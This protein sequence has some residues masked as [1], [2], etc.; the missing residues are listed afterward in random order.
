MLLVIRRE[1]KCLYIVR[2]SMSILIVNWSEKKKTRN[3]TNMSLFPWM[4]KKNL[5]LPN[6]IIDLNLDTF[7]FMLFA[8]FFFSYKSSPLSID[9]NHRYLT[10]SIV[11]IYFAVEC[12]LCFSIYFNCEAIFSIHKISRGISCLANRVCI[13]T[14]FQQK[15]TFSLEWHR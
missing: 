2:V 8:N 3:I 4:K 1:I 7:L 15:L 6:K 12:S 10:Q 13:V 9:K 14:V 5:K 11:F